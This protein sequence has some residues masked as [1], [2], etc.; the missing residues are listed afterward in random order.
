MGRAAGGTVVAKP[1]CAA[2]ASEAALKTHL[3]Q[4]VASGVIS[5][6]AVPQSIRCVEA[7]AKTSVGKINKKLL[8]EQYAG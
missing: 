8:R 2:D 5:K 7:I 3:Q 1:G 6:F 4:F